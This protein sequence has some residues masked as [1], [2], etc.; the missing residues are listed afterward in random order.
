MSQAQHEIPLYWAS[1][2]EGRA[3][4]TGDNA[5]WACLCGREQPLLGYSDR[6]DSASSAS[7]VVCPD[8]GRR[9]RVVSPTARGVPSHVQELESGADTA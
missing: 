8:C 4:R 7:L 9:F 2:H 1:G 6:S 3:A 5:A